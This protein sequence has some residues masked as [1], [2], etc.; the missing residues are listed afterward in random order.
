[1]TFGIADETAQLLA[2]LL[3][4]QQVNAGADDFET[5]A[6]LVVRARHQLNRCIGLRSAVV[7]P[8]DA[9][10]DPL[11]LDVAAFLLALLNTR[12]L[13]VGADDFIPVARKVID[14]KKALAALLADRE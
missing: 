12:T 9:E 4:S 2:D 3:A 11:D 14:A 6:E 1:M 5:I 10:S 8:N 7:M 13:N